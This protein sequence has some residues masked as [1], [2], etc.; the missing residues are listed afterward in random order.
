MSI[1][2]RHVRNNDDAD[3]LS[4]SYNDN[5]VDRDQYLGCRADQLKPSNYLEAAIYPS[6]KLVAK[7]EKS[8][9]SIQRLSAWPCTDDGGRAQQPALRGPTRGKH[10]CVCLHEWA[11]RGPKAKSRCFT[12]FEIVPRSRYMVG[13]A[14]RSWICKSSAQRPS[15]SEYLRP[16]RWVTH[17]LYSKLSHRLVCMAANIACRSIKCQKPLCQIRR[18]VS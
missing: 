4:C 11:L 6:L 16:L 3:I 18:L 14:L 2:V 8:H 10:C 5:S 15:C 13:L 1:N 7:L 17:V 9:M 12:L